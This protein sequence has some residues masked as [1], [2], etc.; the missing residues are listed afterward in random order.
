VRKLHFICIGLLLCGLLAGIARAETFQLTDG[1]PITGE[2]VSFNESGLIL[3]LPDGTYSERLAWTKFSQPDLKKLSENQKIAPFVEPFIEISQEERLQKTAVDVKPVPRLDRPAPQSLLG[4]LFSSSV[5][6]FL[7]LVVY[8]ANI[9]AGYE[10]AVFR[11]QSRPLV[12]GIAAVLPILGPII[13]LCMPTK[14]EKPEEELSPEAAAAA[15]MPA[16]SVPTSPDAAEAEAQTHAPG[17]PAGLPATETYQRG[18]YTF[19]RRFI[20]TKFAKFF[21]VVRRDADKDM[22]LVVKA[23]RGS[24][25]ATRISRIT[26]NDMHV[27]V[28][29]GAASE[30]VMVPFSEIQ[31]IQIKHKDA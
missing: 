23:A 6:I 28:H 5:G 21:G 19:N 17:H 4:A 7:V 1:E 26:G 25:I 2:V 11:A 8:G 24:Y 18:A 15:Q 30:E 9:Y 27:E 3:R 22:V 10:V 31:E 14:I 12:C 16:F 20:E 29:K 13:F